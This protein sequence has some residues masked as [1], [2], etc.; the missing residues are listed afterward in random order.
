MS[1][2][3][4][5]PTREELPEL[6]RW[7]KR[8]AQ[9]LGKLSRQLY[10]V[11]ALISA[12]LGALD[13]ALGTYDPTRGVPFK[14]FA[15]ARVAGE[16][17]DAMKAEKRR[18]DREVLL[19]DALLDRA[20][21]AEPAHEA[22]D[23]FLLY[24]VAAE[25][26]AGGEAGCLRK[27]AYAAL[28]RA[29]APLAPAIKRLLHLRYWEGLAWKD[30]GAGIGLSEQGAKDEDRKL[31]AHLKAVLGLREDAAPIGPGGRVVTLRPPARRRR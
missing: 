18:T 20:D 29:I 9:A 23:A 17:R 1:P 5:H 13:E 26:D 12:A 24:C 27:E 28:H 3:L 19:E 14:S 10:D 11:A 15:R 25:I 8:V 4:H 22:M 6:V 21:G 7:A 30:V 31:R 2:P 16:V